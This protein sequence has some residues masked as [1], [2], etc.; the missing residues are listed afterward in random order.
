MADGRVEDGH[1]TG[2]D[3]DTGTAGQ[4]QVVRMAAVVAD[5]EGHHTTAGDLD[6]ARLEPVV[7]RRDG[8]GRAGRPAHVG[9]DVGRRHAGADGL[10]TGAAGGDGEQ[11]DG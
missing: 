1:L 7:E 4:G 9:G 6:A 3:G 11:R 2:V 10:L 8:D 5:H